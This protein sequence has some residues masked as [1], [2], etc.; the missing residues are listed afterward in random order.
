[1]C[2]VIEDLNYLKTHPLQLL[3]Y[4]ILDYS[5]NS[6]QFAPPLSSELNDINPLLP[7]PSN[8]KDDTISKSE[9]KLTNEEINDVI[10]RI[11]AA[12]A[13]SI[14]DENDHS[15]T[16][17]DKHSFEILRKQIEKV[18]DEEDIELKSEL[19]QQILLVSE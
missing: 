6:R 5:Q 13:G 12:A 14:P 8:N 18:K 11:I 9:E 19:L 16:Q 10:N 15:L 2:E 4:V 7:I 17:M 3:P 1:M